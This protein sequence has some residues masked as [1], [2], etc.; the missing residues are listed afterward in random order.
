ML[1]VVVQDRQIQ[2]MNT[3][4]PASLDHPEIIR[5]AIIQ[6]VCVFFLNNTKQ[7]INGCFIKYNYIIIHLITIVCT[8]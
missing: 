8:K 1:P 3:S 7:L 2:K 5:E 4:H 6:Y